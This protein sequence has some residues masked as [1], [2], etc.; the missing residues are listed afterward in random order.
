MPGIHMSEEDF[1]KLGESAS[2]TVKDQINKSGVVRDPS[3]GLNMNPPDPFKHISALSKLNADQFDEPFAPLSKEE[4]AGIDDNLDRQ[5]GLS[6][7]GKKQ[8]MKRQY[9]ENLRA[10]N[11]TTPRA[12]RAR[13]VDPAVSA[14]RSARKAAALA[15]RARGR[16]KW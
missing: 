6:E 10:Q 12:S 1:R 13:Q 9:R 15:K 11:P 3:T 8:E 16:K 5:Y 4:L 7:S 2:P 14:L